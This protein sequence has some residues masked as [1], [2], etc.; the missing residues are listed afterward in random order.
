MKLDASRTGLIAAALWAA[1]LYVVFAL[2]TLAI[3]PSA[4]R[5]AEPP[6][7]LVVRLA[8]HDDPKVQ[9][10]RLVTDLEAPIGSEAG[11]AVTSMACA[12]S[13]ATRLALWLGDHMPGWDVTEWRCLP[14]AEAERFLKSG[15]T[16]DI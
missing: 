5:A 13:A 4:G 16:T 10:W 9:S 3:A 6:Q 11:P 2:M 8:R 15:H 14:V 12:V 7:A 1:F